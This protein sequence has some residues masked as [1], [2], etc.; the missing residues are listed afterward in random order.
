MEAHEK[1]KRKVIFNSGID[2]VGKNT[3]YEDPDDAKQRGK[4]AFKRRAEKMTIVEM[5]LDERQL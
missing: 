3:E 1:M 4:E 5:N 2:F